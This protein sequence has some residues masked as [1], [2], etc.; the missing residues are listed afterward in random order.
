MSCCSIRGMMGLFELFDSA[1]DS[2]SPPF[3]H[4]L[5]WARSLCTRIERIKAF[6][7]ITL[8]HSYSWVQFV[9]TLWNRYVQTVDQQMDWVHSNDC[10]QDEGLMRNGKSSLR[11]LILI[12]ST[13]AGGN[14]D[15]IS[16]F[17]FLL[18]EGNLEKI[19]I[20]SLE[21]WMHYLHCSRSFQ[22]PSSFH[23]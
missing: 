3:C 6:S 11:I 20:I 22:H 23:P 5:L 12:S 14:S 21:L 13:N 4:I 17:K 18:L 2:K 16:L 1:F 7:L 19:Q 10:C 8:P 9:A 15:Q